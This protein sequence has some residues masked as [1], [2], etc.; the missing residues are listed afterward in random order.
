MKELPWVVEC[1]S[2]NKFFEPIAAFNVRI[3]A[4]W[5]MRQCENNTKMFEYRIVERKES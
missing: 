4:H 5:Y 1:K 2:F 3:A